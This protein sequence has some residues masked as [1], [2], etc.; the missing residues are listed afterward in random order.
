MTEPPCPHPRRR[1]LESLADPDG[2]IPLPR[3]LETIVGERP[4]A[5]PLRRLAEAIAAGAVIVA[6]MLAWRFT[7]LASLARRTRSGSGLPRLR[8]L[9]PR[10][11]S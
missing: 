4:K 2:P 10:R 6:L 3:F 9:R 11:C 7:P 5:R 8:G 1:P